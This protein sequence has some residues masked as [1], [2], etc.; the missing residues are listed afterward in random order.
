MFGAVVLERPADVGGPAHQD[1]VAEEY[2]HADPAL[3]QL[4]RE[5]LVHAADRGLGQQQRQ[6]KED[7]DADDEAEQQHAADG[8]RI[9]LAE[10]LLGRDRLGRGG[11]RVRVRRG[12]GRVTGN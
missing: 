8:D 11:I 2:D 4:E 1:Q 9:A 12:R 5:T 6:Q 7:G 3:G 10:T